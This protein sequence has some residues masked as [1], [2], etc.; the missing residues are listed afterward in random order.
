VESA[1]TTFDETPEWQILLWVKANSMMIHHDHR[2]HGS[3]KT[4]VLRQMAMMTMKGWHLDHEHQSPAILTQRADQTWWVDESAGLLDDVA[5]MASPQNAELLLNRHDD[6]SS[7]EMI[8]TGDE[9]ARWGKSELDEV[10]G[11]D[12]DW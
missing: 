3:Q 9:M 11:G 12:D 2:Q 1:S 6:D 7:R 10:A 8:E 5:T 4:K